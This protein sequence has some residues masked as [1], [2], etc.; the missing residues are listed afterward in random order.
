MKLSNKKIKQFLKK[1]RKSLGASTGVL[2]IGLVSLGM[3][4]LGNEAHADDINQL[5]GSMQRLQMLFAGDSK[6]M[7]ASDY[8]YDYYGQEWEN[9]WTYPFNAIK[10]DG[11]AVIAFCSNFDR[12]VSP[13]YV[14]GNRVGQPNDLGRNVLRNGFPFKSAN[15]LGV[16]N[17]YYTRPD[18][19]TLSPQWF[20]YAATSLAFH[21]SGNEPG[22]DG[23]S[24]DLNKPYFDVNHVAWTDHNFPNG[25][26]SKYLLPNDLR[27]DVKN[28]ANRILNNAR[29]DNRSKERPTMSLSL[30]GPRKRIINPDT[31][32]EYYLHQFKMNMTGNYSGANNQAHIDKLDLSDGSYAIGNGRYVKQ[33]DTIPYDSEL[34]VYSAD[35]YDSDT[36]ITRDVQMSAVP[37]GY[38]DTAIYSFGGS[39][40]RAT[41]AQP[42]G[43]ITANGNFVQDPVKPKPIPNPGPQKTVSKNQITSPGENFI[44]DLKTKAPRMVKRWNSSKNHLTLTDD[45]PKGVSVSKIYNTNGL[46]VTKDGNNKDG[47]DGHH[48]IVLTGD[49]DWMQEHSNQDVDVKVEVKADELPDVNSVNGDTYHMTNTLK[50]DAGIQ[51]VHD[52]K[53]SNPVDTIIKKATTNVYHYDIEKDN[54]HDM[55]WQGKYQDS[56]NNNFTWHNNFSGNGDVVKQQKITDWDGSKE[57]VDLLQNYTK[58]HDDNERY[59]Y[60]WGNQNDETITL[61]AGNQDNSAYFPYFVPK[62]HADGL[63]T[64]I[65]T[66]KQDNGLPFQVEIKSGADLYRE[67]SDFAGAKAYLTIKDTRNGKELYSG[68]KNLSDLVDKDVTKSVY[69]DWT[70]KLNTNGKGYQNGDKIPVSVSLTFDN[71]QKIQTPKKDN[72]D[73]YG[74]TA[75][76]NVSVGNNDV[77]HD[78]AVKNG[79]PLKKKGTTDFGN[80]NI[81]SYTGPEETLKY[82][83]VNKVRVLNEQLQL[84]QPRSASGKSGYGFENDLSMNYQG[85][86]DVDDSGNQGSKLA[87]QFPKAFADGQNKISYADGNEKGTLKDALNQNVK[88]KD[89]ADNNLDTENMMPNDDK[90]KI[91]QLTQEL[92][93]SFNTEKARQFETKYSFYPRVSEINSGTSDNPFGGNLY[94]KD[95]D[96]SLATSDHID[97]SKLRDAGNKFYIPVWNENGDY[98]TKWIKQNNARL[99]SNYLDIDNLR[100]FNQFA[101]M[102]LSTTNP[103]P[104]QDELSLQPTMTKNG[105]VKG[106][107]QRNNDWIN[108]HDN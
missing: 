96:D 66:D 105:K 91:D 20:A 76:Q 34:W 87:F 37:D 64:K 15:D 108:H 30:D 52:Y 25:I 92:P 40:Q 42:I 50:E 61:H 31:G 104:K 32:D 100:P 24:F 106:L 17:L 85:H 38:V 88:F 93:A 49:N 7:T 83:G 58:N 26:D 90:G 46:K 14:S 102:Y 81:N 57:K 22:P 27:W 28:A 69:S 67:M 95:G 47:Q 59:R 82:K 94:L 75:S 13:R 9:F 4:G 73:T 68:Q 54:G 23:G 10:P 6:E 12:A 51:D 53:E 21:S 107:S 41:V 1:H 11:N 48:Q 43:A 97:E 103:N 63:I 80:S 84:K 36:P 56:K 101:K 78:K 33:G 44:Y 77:D 5:P 3:L 89:G 99:G 70:G 19:L 72:Q 2:A 45:L 55:D 74:F 18:G 71:P 39:Y 79:N 62:A 98:A 65:R 29:Y 86:L 35:D 60:A 8:W 16:G